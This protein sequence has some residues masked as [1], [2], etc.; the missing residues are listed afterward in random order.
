MCVHVYTSYSHECMC[1]YIYIYTYIHAYIHTCIHTY[2]HIVYAYIH[3]CVYIYIYMHLSLYTYTHI[4]IYIY[5]VSGRGPRRGPAHPP[6]QRRRR[7]AAEQ[8]SYDMAPFPNYQMQA[9]KGV[10][11]RRL[12][13]AVW[14]LCPTWST[15][16]AY[17]II[18]TSYYTI[19]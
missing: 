11:A 14:A 3:V 1:I 12:P 8:A 6:G 9:R 7:V 13:L 5:Y 4:Y 19:L 10:L 2:I 18:I 16:M 17:T 15:N